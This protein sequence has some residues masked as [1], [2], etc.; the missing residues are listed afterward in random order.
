M[1]ADENTNWEEATEQNAPVVTLI[2]SLVTNDAFIRKLASTMIT[3]QQ[4]EGKKGGIIKSSNYPIDNIDEHGNIIKPSTSGWAIT[5]TGKADF[6]DVIVTG[7]LISSRGI[8]AKKKLIYNEATEDLSVFYDSL[9]EAFGEDVLSLTETFIL[10]GGYIEAVDVKSEHLTVTATGFINGI[11]VNNTELIEND[12]TRLYTEI[13]FMCNY[14]FTNMDEDWN[15]AGYI[16]IMQ[17]F[18]Y[19]DTGEII[20]SKSLYNKSDY[21]NPYTYK[22]K[23]NIIY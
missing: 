23:T 3:L 17:R 7:Q 6:T 22:I 11:Y 18:K 1:L 15:T 2:E 13:R 5:H 20:Y 19:T 21:L 9:I 12:R 14:V 10:C 8:L 4:D 16:I